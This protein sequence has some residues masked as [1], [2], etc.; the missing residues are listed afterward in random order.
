[1]TSDHA[2]SKQIAPTGSQPTA[3]PIR[4][5]AAAR[6]APATIP[7][8]RSACSLRRHPIAVFDPRPHPGAL[9]TCRSALSVVTRN[10][11]C[12]VAIRAKSALAGPPLSSGRAITTSE[13]IAGS[14]CRSR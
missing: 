3:A 9:R 7:A 6:I 2:N 12:G 11:E 1:M 4:A 5:R 13:I 10:P 8:H 14:D